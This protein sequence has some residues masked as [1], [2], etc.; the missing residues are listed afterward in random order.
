LALFALA[1]QPFAD[2]RR[3]HAMSAMSTPNAGTGA[4]ITACGRARLERLVQPS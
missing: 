3:V 2:V 1:Y 4:T